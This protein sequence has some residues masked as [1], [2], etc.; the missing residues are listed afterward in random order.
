MLSESCRCFS[1]DHN[2]LLKDPRHLRTLIRSFRG[3]EQNFG[4][5]KWRNYGRWWYIIGITFP[6]LN[7]CLFYIDGT[8]TS[9]NML[10]RLV[11]FRLQ[12]ITMIM[13]N[14]ECN[15]NK[16]RRPRTSHSGVATRW[17][18][19]NNSPLACL[20]TLLTDNDWWPDVAENRIQPYKLQ[21]TPYVH[22]RHWGDLSEHVTELGW[23]CRALDEM[24]A[25]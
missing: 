4:A 20:D 5:D 17:P 3:S 6:R 11:Y 23:P 13:I 9:V 14:N 7:A 22:F 21:F 16:E 1:S 25:S 15:S 8:K 19:E 18:Y 2:G 10:I 24:L 12:I